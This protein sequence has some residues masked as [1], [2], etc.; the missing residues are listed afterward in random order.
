MITDDLAPVEKYL[1]AARAAPHQ[2]AHEKGFDLALHFDH[3][4]HC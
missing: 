4:R 3:H 1:E 2:Q